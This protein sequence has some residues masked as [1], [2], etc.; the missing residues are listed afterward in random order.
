MAMMAS[1]R[2]PLAATPAPALPTPAPASRTLRRRCRRHGGRG[3][4]GDD[5]VHQRTVRERRD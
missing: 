4:L 1:A 3:Y 5:G 2:A